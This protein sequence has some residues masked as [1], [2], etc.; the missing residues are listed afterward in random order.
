MRLAHYLLIAFALAFMMVTWLAMLRVDAAREA[1]DHWCGA[2]IAGHPVPR[3]RW[4]SIEPCLADYRRAQEE[5][6][7]HSRNY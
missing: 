3:N 1:A 7:I 6:N 4:S 5:A 2:A